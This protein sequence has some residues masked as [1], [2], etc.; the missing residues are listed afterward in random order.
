MR[1]AV[2]PKCENCVHR[3]LINVYRIFFDQEEQKQEQYYICA[4]SYCPYER[5]EDK[6]GRFD[7][8]RIVRE[9]RDR[10]SRV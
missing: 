1:V 4:L 6:R 8:V 2:Y 7:A 3:I 9:G 10:V 5:A